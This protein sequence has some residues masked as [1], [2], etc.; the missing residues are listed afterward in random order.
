M[1]AFGKGSV[2]LTALAMHAAPAQANIYLFRVDCASESYVAQ[3]DAGAVDQGASDYRIATQDRN[4]DCS[5]YDYSA[6]TDRNLPR[7]WCTGAS[8]II[9][10][11]PPLLVLLG[12]THCQ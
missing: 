6:R 9:R 7:R 5:I 11:F 2:L 1:P 3:W 8:G 10:G 12:Q 4:L